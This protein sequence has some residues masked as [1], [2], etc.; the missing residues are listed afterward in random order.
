MVGPLQIV[1]GTISVIFLIVSVVYATRAVRAMLRIFRT[2]QPD[3][4]R[5]KPVGRRLQT[6]LVESLAHTRMLKSALPEATTGVA[7]AIPKQIQVAA[8]E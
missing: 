4:S 6:M 2:G 3:S 7:P 5:T 8:P 1:L